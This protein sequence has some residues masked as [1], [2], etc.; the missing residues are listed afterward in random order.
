MKN[1]ISVKLGSLFLGL[2]VAFVICLAS[3]TWA[4]EKS[5]SE[6]A[7]E[8]ANPNTSIGFLANILDYTTYDGDLPDSDDQDSWR[9]SFQP[10]IPYP[11]A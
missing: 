11:I 5:A 7:N 1:S 4:E 9:Y 8:L 2:V 3:P 10:S 6:I